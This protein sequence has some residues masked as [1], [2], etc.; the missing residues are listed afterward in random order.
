[1][2]GSILSMRRDYLGGGDFGFITVS[3]FTVF[4][5]GFICVVGRFCRVL[6]EFLML[7]LLV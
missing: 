3:L 7:Y 2:G 1:M 4:Y 5:G 6:V